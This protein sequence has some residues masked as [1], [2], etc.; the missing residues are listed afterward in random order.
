MATWVP[1]WHERAVCAVHGCDPGIEGTPAGKR[2]AVAASYCAGCPVKPECAAEALA[3][4]STGVV[5]AGVFIPAT[6]ATHVSPSKRLQLQSIAEEA[7]C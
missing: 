5:R 7:S 3:T 6:A 2:A 1:E 4:R